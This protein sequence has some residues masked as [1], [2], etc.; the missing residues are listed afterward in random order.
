MPIDFRLWAD[1]SARLKRQ[2]AEPG[3]TLPPH[4][5][6][7]EPESKIRRISTTK[8]ALKR[9]LADNTRAA[10]PVSDEDDEEPLCVEFGP[11]GE[12]VVVP[13]DDG[14]LANEP[15]QVKLADQ[16]PLRPQQKAPPSEN[17]DSSSESEDSDFEDDL[18]EAC[19]RSL[20]ELSRGP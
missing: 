3:A 14:P 6:P 4:D 19:R 5:L 20:A 1:A 9:L 8:R 2:R 15:P 16:P 11:S 10:S 18:Q 17:S 13:Q 7:L 12:L